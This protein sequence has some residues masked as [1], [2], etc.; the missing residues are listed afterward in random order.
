MDPIAII[1]RACLLPGAFTPE[2][3]WDAVSAGRDLITTVPEGRWGVAPEDALATDTKVDR[4]ASDRGGYVVGF[5]DVFDPSGFTV[6]ASELDGLD[7]V[8]LWTLHTAR[9]ALRDANIEGAEGVGAIYGNLGF[10]S[11]KMAEFA[12]ERWNGEAATDARNRYMAGGVAHLMKRALSLGSA[13]SLDA[14][15]ASSL[16][17]IKLACDELNSGKRDVMLAGAVQAADDLFLHVGF[18]ALTALSAT[19]QSRPFHRDA[20]GLVPGEGAG[21]V[22]LKRLR[23]AR[24]DGDT[25][26]G[27]VRGVGLS[28]DGRGRGILAPLAAG[29]ERAIRAAYDA[30]ELSPADVSLLECHATGTR[31]GDATELSSSAAVFEGAD[32]LTIGSL[33]SNLGHLITAAGVGGLIK[34][35]EAMRNR[36]KPPSLH[37]DELTDALRGTP[38][39]VLKDLEHWMQPSGP[40]VAGI[41]AFGFGGNNAHLVVS[42]DHPTL[43]VERT[44]S[45][46]PKGVAV[47]ACAISRDPEEVDVPIRGVKFPPVDLKASLP[48]QL[49]LL[50][51]SMTGLSRVRFPSDRAGVFV[52]VE[53]DI[54]VARYGARWRL[55]ARARAEGWDDQDLAAARDRIV[56]ALKSASVIGTMPNIPAN[57]LSSQFDIHGPAFTMSHGTHSGLSAL[58]AAV[59]AIQSGELE[60]ALVGAVDFTN[61]PLNEEAAGCPQAD[62]AVLLVLKEAGAACADGDAI[63]ALLTSD[64]NVGVTEAR[65]GNAARALLTVAEAV[66]DV[67]GAQRDGAPWLPNG[68]P[69]QVVAEG[70]RVVAG[71]ESIG[72]A[73]SAEQIHVLRAATR[74]ALIARLRAAESGGEGQECAVLVCAKSDFTKVCERA[75]EVVEGKRPSGG[76]VHY[77][78]NPVSG[79]VAAVFGGAGTA[80]A[81]MGKSEMT[82]WP[83][84]LNRAGRRSRRLGGA[85]AACWRN[86]GELSVLDRLWG[87]SA[88]AQTHWDLLTGIAD[89]QPDAVIGYSSGE[90]NSLVATGS[91]G[92]VDA[93]VAE[94]EESRLFDE[95]VAGEFQDVVAD[96]GL[97][98]L[99]WQTYAIIGPVEETKKAIADLCHV[100][101][102]II[103]SD[104]NS[105]IAGESKQVAVALERLGES[106]AIRVPYDLA[107]HV[108]ELRLVEAEW[109]ALHTRETTPVGLRVYSNGFGGAYEPTR[110]SCAEAI[111]L[112]AVDTLDFRPTVRAAFEDG[113]RVFIECGPQGSATTAIREILAGEDIVSVALDASKG[114]YASVLHAMA[115]LISA[116][117]EVDIDEL[118]RL[119]GECDAP[120]GP[121]VSVPARLPAPTLARVGVESAPGS[122]AREAASE[123]SEAPPASSP[124]EKSASVR[125]PTEPLPPTKSMPPAPPLPPVRA[126]I[127]LALVTQPPVASAP[128]PSGPPPPPE[129]PRAPTAPAPVPAPSP[130]AAFLDEL[131]QLQ[132]DHFAQQSA[133]HTQYLAFQAESVRVLA[134]AIGA[135]VHA[136][137]PPAIQS[138]EPAPMVPQIQANTR[139]IACPAPAAEP[140]QTPPAVAAP[141]HASISETVSAFP[142]LRMSRE[143][144]L[145]HASGRISD[146][147]GPKFVEQD[148]F[149]R[150]VRMPEGRLLLADRVVGLDAEP[151]SMGRGTI[152]SETDVCWDSWYL[153][154]GYMPAGILIESGQADLV[155][156]SYL[157][158]DHFNR[159]E[160]VYRLL[161][162]ELTYHGDLPKAGETLQ[163]DIHLD[164]HAKHGDVRLMFFHYDCHVDGRPQLSVRAG[165]AGFFT[166]EELADSAGC[167]WAPE[168][169]ELVA[170]ARVDAPS[171]QRVPSSIDPGTL[172]GFS[173]KGAAVFGD[174]FGFAK[175]HTRSPAV[176]SGDMLLLDEITEIDPV[177]GP[178]ERGYLRGELMLDPARLPEERWFYDGHFK[179][180]PCMPGTLMFEGCLQAMSIY[181][182]ALGYTIGRDGWRFQPKPETPFPLSCRGQATPTSKLLTYELFVEEVHAGPIPTLYADVLCTVDGLKAFHGRRIALEL[183]PDWPLEAMPELTTGIVDPEPVAVVDGFKF[184][185]HSMLAAA[186]GRPSEAFGPMYKPFDGPRKVAR[187][188]GPPYHFMSRVRSLDF[189]PGEMKPGAK[190]AIDY[191]IPDSAWYFDVNGAP[192]MP[193][194]VLLEAAL[195]PCGWLASAVGSALTVGSELGFRNLDGKATLH[196]ELRPGDGTLTTNVELLSVSST[197]GMIVQAFKVDCLVGDELVYDLHTVFGFFPPAALSNQAGLPLSHADGEL[198]QRSSGFTVDLGLQPGPHWNAGRPHLADPMLL[199]LDRVT[200]YWPSS[201]EAGL[202][203]LRAEKD[204]DQDEWFFKAHFFQDP[205]QPGSL[206]LEALLQLLQFFMLEERMDD[207]IS[208]PRFEPIALQIEHSWKYRGQ[209]LLHNQTIESTIEITERGSDERGAFAIAKGSLWVDGKRIYEAANIGMRIVSGC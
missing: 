34:V 44:K 95:R 162:C 133:L 62:L 157:G 51:M 201:G 33:K 15:C 63:V 12:A 8:F 204:V 67:G 39:R 88:V 69:R 174:E 150:Q 122:P 136:S 7:R 182:A 52:G 151:A 140:T 13:Y 165:Q 21:F 169:Q 57:R 53:P 98:A 190:V 163:Y 23:D 178:W 205:V 90:S 40:R 207:G 118:G 156:I 128:T 28:N 187:L 29:Q 72:T 25:I 19:G 206:G 146:V 153:N 1:G 46:S 195:Q 108:P 142:G 155:L 173:I 16:Y 158:I 185:Y 107:V 24:R 81:E 56:P 84:A 159:G 20:D 43:S 114:G 194:A 61:D 59:A 106:R 87:A 105:V 130:H 94:S 75:L 83:E 85:L 76:P 65:P 181:L 141:V 112:Q 168:E 188:P 30:A 6:D 117:V 45:S 18:T 148:Q 49:E 102:T 73:P 36:A 179:N 198:L 196:R 126:T 131:S 38:F 99:D 139:S 109:V 4:A 89:I 124:L 22:V 121:F 64:E 71:T 167:L 177:G 191:D 32:E 91:W 208:S 145:V 37:T 144:L 197:A 175:A 127:D 31:V 70:Y 135:G 79:E 100:R 125:V 110:E 170:D 149:E 26:H 203:Q 17:A 55:A 134:S 186:W 193:F 154:R 35:L 5:D 68:E 3:L 42:E 113:V 164:N 129:A 92:D 74:T 86:D 189:V 138:A 180:D 116:G 171:V 192:T 14:A 132:A 103:N 58:K 176:Q 60:A 160:R 93:L 48:Q 27:V 152:W 123:A 199:M 200:G 202:G 183:V 82:A 41:S 104:R 147:F 97:D 161:G 137:P 66:Q 9:A 166:E 209:V 2:E 80:Y 143:D 119:S 172:R 96:W 184:G 111:R 50:R 115:E 11:Q 77:R 47:V 101:L 120:S 54:E 10:P 78:P